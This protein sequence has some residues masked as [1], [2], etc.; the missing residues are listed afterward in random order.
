MDGTIYLENKMIDGATET[1]NYLIANKKHILFVT[2]K[3]T[4]TK[5]DYAKFLK[6]NGVS[7]P[8]NN[9]L[10]AANNCTNFLKQNRSGKNFYAIAEDV[11]IDTIKNAGLVFTKNHEDID[12]IVVSLDR[13][14]SK[15]KFEIAKKA[16]LNGAEFLAANIDNTCPVIEGEIIDAGIII[17]DLEKETGKILLQH[18]GKPSEYMISTIITNLKYK[19]SDYL[20]VGDRLETDILMGNIM[21]LDTMLVNSGVFN[22]IENKNNTPTYNATSIKE[23]LY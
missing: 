2:N 15:R 14:Y 12:I 19:K 11:F 1:L 4:H 16:L 21:E 20:L 13:K 17:S 8:L 3:T 7:I 9:I 22:S 5:V 10:T 23:L 6:N 18:F